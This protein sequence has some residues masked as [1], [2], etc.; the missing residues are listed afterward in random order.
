MLD[1]HMMFCDIILFDGAEGAKPDME[2]NECLVNALCPEVCEQLRR[3]VQTC[4][5]CCR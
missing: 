2:R 5:R 4:R 1:V 3:K